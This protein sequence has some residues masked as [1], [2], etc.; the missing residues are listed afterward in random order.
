MTDD[1]AILL[2]A[3][4][5]NETDDTARLVYADWLQENGQEARAE[6]IRVQVELAWPEPGSST[7]PSITGTVLRMLNPLGRAARREH[8]GAVARRDALRGRERDL[9]ATPGLMPELKGCLGH[10]DAVKGDGPPGEF[11]HL[12]A[13]RGFY[14]SAHCT[15]AAWLRHA[16]AIL[17]AHPVTRVRPTSRWY[18]V[19][20]R[21]SRPIRSHGYG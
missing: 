6:F 21:S 15:V 9:W 3:V 17:A 2:A 1:G 13:R 19:S 11:V 10:I 18:S 20:A 14:E 12:Y 7:R 5:A 16:D 4:L 8:G